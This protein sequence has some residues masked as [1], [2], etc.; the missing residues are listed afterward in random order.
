MGEKHRLNI[1]RFVQTLQRRYR[2]WDA[3]AITALADE[4]ETAL[5]RRLPKRYWIVYNELLVAFG[6]VVCRPVSP[7]CSRCPVS[8]MCPRIGVTRSR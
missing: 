5:R 8:D 7:H 3:P 1:D 2:D 6:Q 4:T